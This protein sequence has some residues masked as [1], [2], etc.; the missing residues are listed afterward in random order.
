MSELSRTTRRIGSRGHWLWLRL[1]QLLFGFALLSMIETLF[2]TVFLWP[3]YD[4]AF[5]AVASSMFLYFSFKGNGLSHGY[6]DKNG[7]YYW[8]YFWKMR[9]GWDEVSTVNWAPGYIEVIPSKASFI[10]QPALFPRDLPASALWDARIP[11]SKPEI[12]PWLEQLFSSLP[13]APKFSRVYEFEEVKVSPWTRLREGNFRKRDIFSLLWDVT[14][15]ILFFV[16]IF[17]IWN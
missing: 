14:P 10:N 4:L 13:T 7:I 1:F 3:W 15:I 8:R 11:E 6:A 9:L 17:Y 12:V 2:K 5:F 16:V